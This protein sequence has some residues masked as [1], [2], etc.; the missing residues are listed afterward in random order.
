M[1]VL[2]GED[3]LGLGRRLTVRPF[4]VQVP[5]EVLDDLRDRLHRTRW[6][7]TLESV[8]WSRGVPVDQLRGLVEHWRDAYDWR[9]VEG[10]LNA[11]EQVRTE[12]D[13]QTIHA[14]HARSADPHALPLVLTHGWP[15]SVLDYL[16][17]LGPLTAPGPDAFHVV[18]PH[19][20]GVGWSTPLSAEGGTIAGSPGRGRCSWTRSGTRGTGA[21][22]GTRGRWSHR[23]SAG[24]R[25]IGW[26][27]CTCTETWTCR[28]SGRTTA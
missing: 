12:I 2:A 23:S 8:G 4:T 19:L 6:P 1:G 18:V 21:R 3:L 26:S 27:G 17:L 22:A 14:L 15:G 16:D 10:R 11:V 13:G 20:P 7:Q 28:R 24:W 25:P 9:A 5:G